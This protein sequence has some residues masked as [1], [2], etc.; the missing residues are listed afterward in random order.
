MVLLSG[1]GRFLGSIKCLTVA[2]QV[3]G[4]S[5]DMTFTVFTTKKKR[6]EA[7]LIFAA[8]GTEPPYAD[9][10]QGVRMNLL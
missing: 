2:T 7:A 10:K 3:T 1:G 9:H 5:D 6:D 8:H 4:D